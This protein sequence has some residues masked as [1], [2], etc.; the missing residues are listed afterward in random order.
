MTSGNLK[1]ILLITLLSLSAR[2]TIKQAP[3]VWQC[4][5]NGSPRFFYCVHSRTKQRLKL[6][7][8]APEMKAA[9]C[10]S[11]DD[12]KALMRW[13]DYLIDQATRRCN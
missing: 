2:K 12:Y 3:P 5:V 1:K 9:Q 4:Q 13:V 10:V 11:A 6:P 7:I 8:D